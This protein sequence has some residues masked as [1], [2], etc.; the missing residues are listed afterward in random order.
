KPLY[1]SPQAGRRE[2]RPDDRARLTYADRPEDHPRDDDRD[3][4]D[5]ASSGTRDE[6]AAHPPGANRSPEVIDHQVDSM[7]RSPDCECPACPVP[8][9]AQHHGDQEI[10]ISSWDPFAT[11]PEWDVEVIAQ[12]S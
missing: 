2:H 6:I 9:P 10:Q 8:Q 5:K 7:Q 12:E 3:E 1:H 4:R 11:S